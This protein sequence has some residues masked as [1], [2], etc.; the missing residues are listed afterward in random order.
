VER[1][2]ARLS[3]PPGKAQKILSDACASGEVRFFMEQGVFGG[4][5]PTRTTDDLLRLNHDLSGADLECWL[6]GH[7]PSKPTS[8]QRGGRPTK[9]D[10]TALQEAFRLKVQECGWPE[11]LNVEGWQRQADVEAWATKLLEDRDD[12]SITERTARSYAQQLLK[13]Q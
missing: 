11:P 3:I 4:R 9:G 1:I 13:G 8:K 2:R 6:D 7:H 5:D 10:L 12:I